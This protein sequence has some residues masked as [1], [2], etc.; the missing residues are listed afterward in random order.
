MT[1]L[2]AHAR[3]GKPQSGDGTKS[4]RINRTLQISAAP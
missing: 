2:A 1:K 3:F 4:T